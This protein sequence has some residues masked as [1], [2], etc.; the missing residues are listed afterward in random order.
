[1]SD[2]LM[3]DYFYGIEADRY[4]FYRIPKVLIKHPRFKSLSSDAKI[5]YGLMLDRMGHIPKNGEHPSVM[6]NGTRFTV[7]EVSD[8]RISKVL[9]V[10]SSKK[11]ANKESNK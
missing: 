3:F 6:I 4:T 11:E 7:T 5:A 1:M 2:A 10:M 9:I 8:R